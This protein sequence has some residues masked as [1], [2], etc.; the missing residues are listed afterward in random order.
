MALL[1]FNLD[2]VLDVHNEPECLGRDDDLL[3]L[4]VGLDR[5]ALVGWLKDSKPSGLPKDCLRIEGDLSQLVLVIW[6]PGAANK[7]GLVLEVCLQSL[8]E[9]GPVRQAA[10]DRLLGGLGVVQVLKRIHVLDCVDHLDKPRQA[11]LL[12]PGLSHEEVAA[13]VKGLALGAETDNLWGPL[14]VMAFDKHLLHDPSIIPFLY[15]L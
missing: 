9:V 11:F 5:K 7:L 1:L 4:P 2:P 10:T 8:L 15:A 12:E 13:V 3:E 6:R 14:N